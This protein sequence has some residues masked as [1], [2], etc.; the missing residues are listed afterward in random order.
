MLVWEKFSYSDITHLALSLTGY[1]GDVELPEPLL[2]QRGGHVGVTAGA[3]LPL[4]VATLDTHHLVKVSWD[5]ENTLSAQTVH[6]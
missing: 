3:R 2:E 1:E 4:I 5:P 6:G